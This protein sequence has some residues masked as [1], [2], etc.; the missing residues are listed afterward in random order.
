MEFFYFIKIEFFKR[1]EIRICWVFFFL[2]LG[3]FGLVYNKL[4]VFFFVV[5]LF[6]IK[7]IYI[8]VSFSLFIV[9]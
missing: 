8:I 6:R 5:F 9:D 7:A 2:K 4:F 1:R 3:L